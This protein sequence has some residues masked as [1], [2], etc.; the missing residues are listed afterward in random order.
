MDPDLI[1]IDEAD[2]FGSGDSART[3]RVVAYATSKSPQVPVALFSAT[4]LKDG[5][6]NITHLCKLALGVW[7][8]LPREWGDM[9][10]VA[11]AV[12]PDVYTN[13]SSMLS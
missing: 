13:I 4:F 3:Q 9:A 8:P 12:D 1:L 11:S 6:R 5:L 2:A 10:A 7:S